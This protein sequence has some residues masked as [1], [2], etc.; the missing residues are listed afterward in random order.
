MTS[1]L[2]VIIFFMQI[3]EAISEYIY[4]LRIERGSSESTIEGYGR[5]LE[6]YLEFLDDRGV[7]DLEK[8]DREDIAAY[9]TALSKEDYSPTSIKR[10]MSAIR[11]FHKFAIKEGITD[12]SPT[13]GLKF[14]KIPDKLPDVITISEVSDMLDSMPHDT[15]LQIRDKAIMEMLYGCGLRASEVCGLDVS[16]VNLDEGFMIAFGKGSKERLVPISGAAARALDEYMYHGARAALSMKAKTPQQYSLSA[17]FLNARG[18]RL[19]RQGLFGIV[20]ATGEAAGIDDLHP[21]TL[22][23]SFATH[24]LEGGADLRVI[25]QLLGHS[26]ISTTQIYTHVNRQHIKEEY[27]AAHPRSKGHR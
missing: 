8:I 3:S 7:Y 27:L 17:V 9:Q 19:T 25:Q 20:K 12:N 26:D 22:R 14:P 2:V 4:Y 16:R 10:K 13:D 1:V 5:D 24:M 18:G 15:P 23:H 6:G 11:G 21:H